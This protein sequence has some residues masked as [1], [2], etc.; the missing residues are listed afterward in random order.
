M[1][2]WFEYKSASDI[3]ESGTVEKIYIVEN[4]LLLST[5]DN[6]FKMI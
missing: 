5:F 1:G 6:E 4:I 2:L 3:D